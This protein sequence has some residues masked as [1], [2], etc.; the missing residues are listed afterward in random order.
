MHFK[1]NCYEE[2]RTSCATDLRAVVRRH[3]AIVG[4]TKKA[5]IAAHTNPDGVASSHG[6]NPCKSNEF[7]LGFSVIK[8]RLPS[9]RPV[10]L[11]R[12]GRAKERGASETSRRGRNLHI[13][14][15][16]EACRQSIL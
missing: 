5:P 9:I 10:H 8:A 13:V 4:P 1:R 14:T 3:V 15:E 6:V 16:R 7:W 11:R 12:P 2:L